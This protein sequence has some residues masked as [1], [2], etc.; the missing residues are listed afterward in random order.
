MDEDSD[1]ALIRQP[2]RQAL[3]GILSTGIGL[4]AVAIVLGVVGSPWYLFAA[5]P[6]VGLV[7]EVWCL[8][9]VLNSIDRDPFKAVKYLSRV[10]GGAVWVAFGLVVPSIALMFSAG[11]GHGFG[12][13]TAVAVAV[14]IVGACV[15]AAFGHRFGRAVRRASLPPGHPG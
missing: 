7:G 9:L 14:A 3:I 10:L 5:G 12:A 15:A 11:H 8:A 13:L 2:A 6:A 1:L 4:V